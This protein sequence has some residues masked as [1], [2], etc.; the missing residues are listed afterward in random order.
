MGYCRYFLYPDNGMHVLL[1][2]DEICDVWVD[3][4]DDYT[5]GQSVRRGIR[6]RHPKKGKKKRDW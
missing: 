2:H 5:A 6:A 3:P 4:E 1:S